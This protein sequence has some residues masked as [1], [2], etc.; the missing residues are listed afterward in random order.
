MPNFSKRALISAETPRAV[1]EEMMKLQSSDERPTRMKFRTG[2]AE[3]WLNGVVHDSRA[4]EGPTTRIS[5]PAVN[6]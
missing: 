4:R 6:Q 3:R 5:V 1:N 2:P